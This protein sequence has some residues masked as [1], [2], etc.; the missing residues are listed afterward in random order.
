MDED[1]R[2]LN[3]EEGKK[4][5]SK[6]RRQLRNKVSARAFRSRRKEYISQLEGQVAVKVNEA[7]ALKRENQLLKADN[8]SLRHLAET[9]ISHPAFMPFMQELSRDP[10]L[11]ESLARVSNG[12]PATTATDAPKEIPQ[13]NQNSDVIVGMTLIPEMPVDLSSLNIGSNQWQLPQGIESYQTP[14]VFAVTEVS[15]AAAEPLDIAALSGKDNCEVVE[16]VIS[17][18]L[19]TAEQ[20]PSFP[21]MTVT[22][23]KETESA[24]NVYDENDPCETLFAAPSSS[25]TKTEQPEERIFG[26]LPT[27][28]AFAR[29]ELVEVSEIDEDVFESELMSRF[30][31][32]E[33]S[34]RNLQRLTS[35]YR[36]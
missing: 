17:Q 29:Y 12:P 10:A 32:V 14:Q 30:A 18:Y 33:A 31:R 16:S 27:E 35:R 25:N 21:E 1:E 20:K 7:N 11:A 8:E 26:E 36:C 22:Q 34:F 15:P 4:L 2:L 24:D 19:D 28:K 6:E 23:A 3:S 5:S 13:F 9:L